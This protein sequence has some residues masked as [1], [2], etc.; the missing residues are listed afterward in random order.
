MLTR[1][2]GFS[3]IYIQVSATIKRIEKRSNLLVFTSKN[4]LFKHV[5]SKARILSA[6][7]KKDFVGTKINRY[8][9][10]TMDRGSN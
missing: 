1:E 10:Y 8:N 2:I 5:L 9:L 6:A 7:I 4:K 3:K